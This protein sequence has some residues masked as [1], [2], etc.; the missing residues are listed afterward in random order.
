VQLEARLLRERLVLGKK[1]NAIRKYF[2][3]F[4]KKPY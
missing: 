2:F 4:P 1:K 3:F